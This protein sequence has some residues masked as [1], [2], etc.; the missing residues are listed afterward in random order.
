MGLQAAVLQ[1][2]RWPGFSVAPALQIGPVGQ[3]GWKAAAL[4]L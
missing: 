1:T 2:R 3:R 4:H